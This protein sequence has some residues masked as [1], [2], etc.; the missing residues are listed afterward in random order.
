MNYVFDTIKADV[1]NHTDN[2]IDV[3]NVVDNDTVY[4]PTIR[5][6]Y[7]VVYLSTVNSQQVN[8]G[9]ERYMEHTGFF[10][11]LTDQPHGMDPN[12]FI[13]Y[14]ME[15]YLGINT[16][17][18][19]NILNCSREPLEVINGRDKCVVKIEYQYMELI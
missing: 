3:I 1:Q 9:E 16:V 10:E 19:I 12:M 8:I 4:E 6:L 18:D 7:M 17:N 11:C 14:L 2:Y 5:D 15:R 13:D